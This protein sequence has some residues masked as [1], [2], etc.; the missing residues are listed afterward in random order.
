MGRVFYLSKPKLVIQAF[1]GYSLEI[2]FREGTQFFLSG[3]ELK[4]EKKKKKSAALQIW[5]LV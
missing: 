1:V 3:L 4:K 5:L 2:L